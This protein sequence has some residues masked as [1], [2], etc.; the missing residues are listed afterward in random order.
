MAK[1]ETSEQKKARERE[2]EEERERGRERE[3]ER[4]EERERESE[5]R[6]FSAIRTTMFQHECRA[7]SDGRAAPRSWQ[8]PLPAGTATEIE[9]F[10]CTHG[11]SWP[12]MDYDQVATGSRKKLV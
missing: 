10:F 1:Q 8:L 2:R 11:M 9:R 7:N 12:L 6:A 4:E 3:R 5:R